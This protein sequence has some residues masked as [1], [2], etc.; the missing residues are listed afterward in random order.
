MSL[1]Q[2]SLLV[3]IVIFVLIGLHPEQAAAAAKTT[4]AKTTAATA[5]VYVDNQ[6]TEYKATFVDHQGPM[7]PIKLLANKLKYEYKYDSS[8]GYIIYLD[9]KEYIFKANKPEVFVDGEHKYTSDLYPRIINGTLNINYRFLTEILG[10]PAV[11][12]LKKS[13][14]KFSSKR[15]AM[16]EAPDASKIMLSEIKYGAPM[17]LDGKEY[18][19]RSYWIRNKLS[20]DPESII[21]L[22]GYDYDY[23]MNKQKDDFRLEQT[24]KVLLMNK[25][26]ITWNSKVISEG[27]LTLHTNG[28]ATDAHFVQLEPI[29]A[30]YGYKINIGPAKIEITSA[31]RAAGND[32]L[33]AL[34]NNDVAKTKEL[35]ELGADP[36][37]L[38]GNGEPLLNSVIEKKELFKL[39]LDYGADPSTR[40]G[41]NK[42]SLLLTVRDLESFEYLLEKGARPN[43]FNLFGSILQ[44]YAANAEADYVEALLKYGADVNSIDNDGNTVLMSVLSRRVGSGKLNDNT[45]RIIRMLLENKADAGIKNHNGA[46]AMSLAITNNYPDEVLE[47]LRSH[48]AK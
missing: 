17:Y 31:N 10:Y 18:W 15:T 32:L 14:L 41:S 7:V 5:V 23:T 40:T 9:G 8:K 11:L 36:N 33:L 48:G 25:D 39:L 46:T 4:A 22:L 12:D 38:D 16:P 45:T 37:A 24:H 30:A 19:S 34:R 43:A 35:L 3:L 21:Y 27:I 26:N 6:K 29:L 47:L 28:G 20:I 13:T 1:K 2:T 44:T 42:R